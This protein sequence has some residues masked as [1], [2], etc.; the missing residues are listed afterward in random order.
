MDGRVGKMAR[1]MKYDGPA[2]AFIAQYI[3]E[4]KWSP[5]VR[6]IC[7]GVGMQSNG[8]T[9]LR[10]LQRLEAAGLIRRGR[11]ARQIVVTEAGM[12]AV[13]GEER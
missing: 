12:R 6:E 5:A 7:Q 13:K 11:G 3:D 2:L 10:V 1:L 4:Q 8:R 9:I